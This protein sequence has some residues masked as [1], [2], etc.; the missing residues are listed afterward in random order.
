[1]SFTVERPY[2][3]TFPRKNTPPVPGVCTL[4]GC[5]EEK[6]CVKGGATCAWTDKE[7]TLCTACTHRVWYLPDGKAVKSR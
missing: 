5:T 4:C 7:Q 6:P 3:Y 2:H 1:M